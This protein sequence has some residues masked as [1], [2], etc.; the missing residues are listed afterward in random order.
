MGRILNR[1][2]RVIE[3]ARAQP[4]SARDDT[5]RNGRGH[6]RP[7]PAQWAL[8]AC[9][10]PC[11]WVG[12]HSDSERLRGPGARPG[13]AL[14]GPPPAVV[15]QL[16]RSLC[17]GVPC[18]PRP[19]AG[20]SLCPRPKP[21]GLCGHHRGSTSGIPRPPSPRMSRRA[22]RTGALRVRRNHRPHGHGSPPHWRIVESGPRPKLK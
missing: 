14:S 21:R 11:W 17:P 12:V 13:E 20:S 8:P 16:R 3:R 22:Q 1:N 4:R 9:S 18:G 19:C 2:A 7:L 5:Q 15:A 10:S 6:W